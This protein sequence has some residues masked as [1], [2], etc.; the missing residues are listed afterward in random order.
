MSIKLT[1]E[2]SHAKYRFKSADGNGLSAGARIASLI[3]TAL[4]A[5]PLFLIAKWLEPSEGLMVFIYWLFS[6]WAI[7]VLLYGLNTFL[8]GQ[9]V[10]EAKIFWVAFILNIPIQ[11]WIANL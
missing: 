4:G 6:V 7:W 1:E 8:V 3:L 11:V 2:Y 9:K 10:D 5:I